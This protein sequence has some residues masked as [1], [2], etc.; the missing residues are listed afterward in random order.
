M[1][2][3]AKFVTEHIAHWQ[4]ELDQPAYPYRRQWP[5]RLFHHAPLENAVSILNSGML[6]SRNDPSNIRQIDVAAQ[7]VINSRDH[8]HDRVRL[9]FR[10]KTPTQFHIEGIRKQGESHFGETAH[11]PILVM[12]I[13]DAQSVLTLPDVKFCDRNMQSYGSVPGGDE[14]YFKNIPF[15]KVYHEGPTGGDQ[16]I[17]AHRCAEVLPS[18]PLDLSQCLEAVWLRSEPERE[19]LLH[20]LGG[21]GRKWASKCQVSE[22]LK[23]FEKRYSFVTYIGIRSNGIVF[24]LNPRFDNKKVSFSVEVFTV[25]GVRVVRFLNSSISATPKN[26]RRWIFRHEFSEGRYRVIAR[27]EG[28]LAFDSTL[29]LGPELF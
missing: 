10:P 26:K 2:L 18:S 13:L 29:T 7:E 1:A 9:Y 19:T 24:S 16:S 27:I 17:T 15:D 3:S 11:A 28:H 21:A 20:Q 5:S 22:A 4:D 8:A 12:L 23:V 25:E 14:A 6:R